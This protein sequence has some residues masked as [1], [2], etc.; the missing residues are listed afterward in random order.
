MAISEVNAFLILRYF[1]YC[2]LCHKGIPALLE[3]YRNLVWKIIKN[4]Y[5]LEQV[6]G[7]GGDF[8]P[9]SIHWLMNAPMHTRIYHNWRWIC[10][11]KTAYQQYSCSFKC[12]KIYG[13]TVYVTKECGYALIVIFRIF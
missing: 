1:V 11:A 12:R 2:G 8:F 13:P 9:D 3:F 4:I 10:T 6:G 5:I 7:G